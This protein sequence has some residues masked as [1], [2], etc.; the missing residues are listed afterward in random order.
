LTTA[1]FAATACG[2]PKPP[3]EPV[4]VV[5]V[6]QDVGTTPSNAPPIATIAV[7]PDAGANAPPIATA[8]PPA[9]SCSDT[10]PVAVPACDMKNPCAE[11]QDPRALCRAWARGLTPRAAAK[12]VSCLKKSSDPNFLCDYQEHAKCAHEGFAAACPDPARE[13]QHRATCER[14]AK[15]CKKGQHQPYQTDAV[16]I[17]KCVAMMSATSPA[18]EKSMI[19][20]FEEY[21]GGADESCMEFRLLHGGRVLH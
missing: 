19:A 18:G 3:P 1:I 14:L 8:D 7:A 9:Q 4:N 6:P 16:D 10:T 17:D 2:T 21:C 11:G 12:V 20:C 15:G 13:K 5:G